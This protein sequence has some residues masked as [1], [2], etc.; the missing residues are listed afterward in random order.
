MPDMK[1][2]R[3]IHTVN[4]AVGGPIES[5][6]QSSALLARRGHQVEIVTLDLPGDPW[7]REMPV[8][9]HAPLHPA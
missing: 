7:T 4:P 3:S 5:V 2:L 1:I 6:R 9:V 8:P